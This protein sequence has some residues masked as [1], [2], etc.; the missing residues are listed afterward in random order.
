MNSLCVYPSWHSCHKSFFF[1]FFSIFAS[2]SGVFAGGI[3][4]GEEQLMEALRGEAA[5]VPAASLQPHRET[6]R[7]RLV[8]DWDDH[9]ETFS[10]QSGRE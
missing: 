10:S 7:R 2:Q 5:D 4:C 9:L 3:D 1:F 6:E 8:M